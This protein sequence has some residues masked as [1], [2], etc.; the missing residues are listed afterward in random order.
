MDPRFAVDN[1]RHSCNKS[2]GSHGAR[3]LIQN[4]YAQHS[5][6]HGKRLGPVS[7]SKPGEGLVV[8]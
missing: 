8:S 1:L 6:V 4:P 2:A 3:P 5:A 7:K